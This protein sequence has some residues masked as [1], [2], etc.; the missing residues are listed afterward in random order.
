MRT[1]A[2]CRS[3][4]PTQLSTHRRGKIEAKTIEVKAGEILVHENNKC[5]SIYIVRS[6]QF[7]AYK[8]SPKGEKIPLGLIREGE[9]I[10]EI[11]FLIDSPHTNSVVALT[12]ASVSKISKEYCD[13]FYQQLPSWFK[14]MIQQQAKRLMAA[15][16]ILRRNKLIDNSLAFSIES[17]DKSKKSKK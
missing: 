4:F 9:Y 2:T 13:K 7:E 10:G 3:I 15:N 1:A 16:D 14:V 8:R 5:D 6:G 12:K 17:A 11:S